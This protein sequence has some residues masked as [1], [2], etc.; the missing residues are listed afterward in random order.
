MNKRYLERIKV[1]KA[2]KSSEMGVPQDSTQ[3]DGVKEVQPTSQVQTSST[4][5]NF[6]E[7]E[8][9][10]IVQ[11]HN[12]KGQERSISFIANQVAGVTNEAYPALSV[13]PNM[14]V[15]NFTMMDQ[16]LYYSE[17]ALAYKG[18]YHRGVGSEI[19]PA[20]VK[21][22]Y[23]ILAT[24]RVFKGMTS[25]G[26]TSPEI[27]AFINTLECHADMGK[28]SVDK[29]MAVFLKA[30]SPSTAA[31][32]HHANIIFWMPLNCADFKFKF[33]GKNNNK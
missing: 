13:L 14:I 22:Y 26:I 11:P 2:I 1:C 32:P 27:R 29:N 10:K 3:Q 24:Y 8:P 16:V 15:P 21:L 18:N 12:P 4:D 17:R 31:S 5:P 33:I 9:V 30:L 6:K 28:C 7:P 20:Y 25:N 19:P 23:Y